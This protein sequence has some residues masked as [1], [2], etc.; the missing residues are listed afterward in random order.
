MGTQEIRISPDPSIED[1][2]A[3]RGFRYAGQG[4]ESEVISPRFTRKQY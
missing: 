3:R 4:D 2:L 1:L